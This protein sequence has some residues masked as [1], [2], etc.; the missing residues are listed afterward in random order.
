MGAVAEEG[1]AAVGD[2]DRVD[3]GDDRD[4]RGIVDPKKR[5]TG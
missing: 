5:T 2:L 3:R 1:E 4:R